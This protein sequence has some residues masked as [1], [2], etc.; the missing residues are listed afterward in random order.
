MLHV[1]N[2][3]KRKLFSASMPQLHNMHFLFTK[4]IRMAGKFNWNVIVDIA[5]N[6]FII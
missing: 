2:D 3:S 5:D 1:A 4:N 6:M